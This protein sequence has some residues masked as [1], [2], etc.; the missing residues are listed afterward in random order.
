[1]PDI[2]PC[3]HCG[4]KTI[5]RV[6]HPAG[7]FLECGECGA[8]GP[9]IEGEEKAVAAWDLVAEAIEALRR[10]RSYETS[11]KDVWVGTADAAYRDLD[12]A[13]DALLAARPA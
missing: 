3:Y 10:C 8:R 13:A 12:A 5:A 4:T 1:M 9:I 6:W 2:K 7:V 11:A